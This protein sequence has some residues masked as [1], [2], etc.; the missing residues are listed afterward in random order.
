MESMLRKRVNEEPRYSSLVKKYEEDK[1]ENKSVVELGVTDL[2]FLPTN[3][4]A[5]AEMLDNTN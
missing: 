5:R 4:D 1:H 3:P 2:N